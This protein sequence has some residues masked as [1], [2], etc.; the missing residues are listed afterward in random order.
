M[1]KI[2]VEYYDQVIDDNNSYMKQVNRQ[3]IFEQVLDDLD[4]N[5]LAIFLNSK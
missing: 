5:K 3:D 2:S 4:I 1:Y